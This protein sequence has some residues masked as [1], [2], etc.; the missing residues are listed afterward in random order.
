MTRAEDPPAPLREPKR[1]RTRPRPK[2]Q[3]PP[4]L[5]QQRGPAASAPAAAAFFACGTHRPPSIATEPQR[6][7]SFSV[8]EQRGNA[9]LGRG[10][11]EPFSRGWERGLRGGRP[12]VETHDELCCV[13]GWGCLSTAGVRFCGRHRANAFCSS[14]TLPGTAPC[15]ARRGRIPGRRKARRWRALARGMRLAGTSRPWRVIDTRVIT[16]ALR[17]PA[18]TTRARTPGQNAFDHA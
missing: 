13:R 12:C 3:P 7:P 6:L 14:P 1:N 5:R 18:P 4:H 16:S 10:K 17:S 8:A 11:A 2:Q 15:Q 9:F